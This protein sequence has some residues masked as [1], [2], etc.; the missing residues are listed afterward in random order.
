[1]FTLLL[2]LYMALDQKISMNTEC[3]TISIKRHDFLNEVTKKFFFFSLKRDYSIF[4][5]NDRRHLMKQE[6]FGFYTGESDAQPGRRKG[7]S[8]SCSWDS[9]RRLTRWLQR[10]WPHGFLGPPA[11]EQKP[12]TAPLCRGSSV[13]ISGAGTH[14]RVLCSMGL[15]GLFQEAAG[16][17]SELI[18]EAVFISQGCCNTVPPS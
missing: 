1:M 9:Q 15:T 16:V 2:S 14:G 8:F 7:V 11:M 13:L 10:C 12:Q 6:S 5:C 3:Y 17:C 4:S 18:P